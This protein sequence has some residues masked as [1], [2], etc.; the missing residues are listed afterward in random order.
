ML[1][2]KLFVLFL[3]ASCSFFFIDIIAS[4]N[5]TIPP[6]YGENYTTRPYAQSY[7]F[8]DYILLFNILNPKFIIYHTNHNDWN[9]SSM[10]PT[11]DIGN[12][13][14]LEKHPKNLA[15]GDIVSVKKGNTSVTHRITRFDGDCFW[16]GGDNNHGAEEGCFTENDTIYRVFAVLYTK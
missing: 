10:N 13:L 1:S 3:V 6:P 16:V 5:T 8:S 2:K 12:T 15:I 9:T 7:N 11:F 14:I 4:L